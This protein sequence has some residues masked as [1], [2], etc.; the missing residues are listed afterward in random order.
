MNC[1]MKGMTRAGMI[2]STG[3]AWQGASGKGIYLILAYFLLCIKIVL[4]CK[5]SCCQVQKEIESN[6]KCRLSALSFYACHN[7]NLQT[8]FPNI[9]SF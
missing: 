6:Y 4:Y 1:V 3:V 9:S 8:H 2:N 7:F 5:K